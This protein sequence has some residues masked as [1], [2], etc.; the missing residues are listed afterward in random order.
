MKIV[1]TASGKQIINLSKKE[2]T[3]IGKKAGWMKEAEF[4]NVQKGISEF[5]NLAQS[6]Y[7][8][9][10]DGENKLQIISN[11]VTSDTIGIGVKTKKINK[12]EA[13]NLYRIYKTIKDRFQF[14]MG[15]LNSIYNATNPEN[16]SDDL[17]KDR[18]DLIGTVD[19]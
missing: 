8:G 15:P 2:W 17:S 1:K 19:F 10:V 18:S 11:E 3:S 14:W 5:T 4:T 7:D 12:E 13:I 16:S 9:I 6:L